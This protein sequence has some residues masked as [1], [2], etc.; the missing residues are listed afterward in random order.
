[1]RRRGAETNFPD[2]V[3]RSQSEASG[4]H[5]A[6]DPVSAE[7]VR[8]ELD[9]L[10]ASAAFRSSERLV[11][12]LRY[13]VEAQLAGK[14]DQVK[15][16]VLALEVFDRKTSYDLRGGAIVRVEARRLR[17]KLA[18]YYATEGRNSRVII[19][20]PKGGYAPTFTLRAGEAPVGTE[21]TPPPTAVRDSRQFPVKILA[22]VAVA[23]LIAVVVT[24][25]IGSRGAMPPPALRRLTSD[26]GLTFQPALSPDGRLLVYSSSRG[27][28][29]NLDIWLQQV[30]GGLPAQ[31]TDNPAHDVDPAFSPDGTVIAYRAE[32]EADGV[33]LVPTLGGKRTLLARGGHRPRF[34]PDGAQLVY[35]T[36]ERRFRTGQI[37]IVPT[38]GGNPVQFRPEFAYAAYPIWSPDGRYLAFVGSKRRAPSEDTNT[39]DWDWWIA[40]IS[41]GPAVPLSVRKAFERQALAPEDDWARQR[42]VPG[43]WTASGHLVFAARSGDRSNIWRLPI[44]PKDWRLTGPA[45][46]LTFGAGR[47][48]HPSMSADGDLVFSVLTR[49]SDV[50]ALPVH[51][52][53]AEPRG[54]PIQLTSGAGDCLWPFVSRDGARIAFVSNR[55]GSSEVWVEDLKAGR[56][57]A[58]TA[59]REDKTSPIISPDGSQVAFSQSAPLPESVFIVPF[60]GGK[61]TQLCSDCGE[62]RTWLSNGMGLLYQNLFPNGDSLIGVLDLSGRTVPLVRSSDSA[63]F[64]ASITR[65][66]RWLALIERTPPNDHRIVVVP[67][68]G[69]S[70]AARSEW[71]PVSEL[72]SW[73]DKP[74]WSPSG[75]LLYYVSDRDGF[76]CLW[77][78]RLDPATK[79]PLGAPASIAHFHASSRSIENTYRLELSVADD[80]LVFNLGETTG[81]IWL[82]PAGG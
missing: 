32:G 65:D 54:P 48:N 73:V 62:A 33:Y 11:R 49:R 75:N 51:A 71:I 77:A 38:A 64:S 40:P 41:G 81:D 80:K 5:G 6:A 58:L 47:E 37:F 13:V 28:G 14:G 53:T 17:N 16:S 79:K 66:G 35:W 8:A 67:L 57:M 59:T 43:C 30:S 61:I 56:A 29:G 42:I 76:I 50:W 21:P 3:A 4:P 20:L 52:D 36:G 63:F 2:H 44:S 68:R 12:F 70:A 22:F 25:W 45:E 7:V 69:R 15:E 78:S 24:R 31:L 39:D 72:G 27:G 46:R 74:R 9:R 34:S 18:D 10:L 1:M 19:G 82:A 60:G 23:G 55:T 26:P